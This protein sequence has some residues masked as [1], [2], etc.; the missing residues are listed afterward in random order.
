VAERVGFVAGLFELL[1]PF[2][3]ARQIPSKEFLGHE[4]ISFGK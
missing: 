2:A 3:L 4:Q 1:L